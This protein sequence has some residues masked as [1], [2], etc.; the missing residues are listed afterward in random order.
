MK[1]TLVR[2]GE[3]VYNKLGKIQGISNIP[4]SD[5]GRL[6]CRKLKDKIKVEKFDVCF[7]S[8]LIRTMETAMIL[9]GDKIPINIDDRLIERDLGELDGKFFDEYDAKK[10]WD[11]NLNCDDY[12]VEKIQDIFVRANSFI[13]YLKKKYEDK[14]ILIV[15][16]AAVIRA[17]HHILKNSNLN[18]NLLT[19]DIPNCYYEEIE[20]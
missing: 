14:S 10:Y 16:H 2:H 20:I 19:F 7:S 18:N 12:H 1:V 17:L 15:S 4:L 8:P 13:D 6:Q 3:T 11:Y 9:V 5:D